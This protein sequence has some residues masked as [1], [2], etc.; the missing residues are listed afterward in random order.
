[1]KICLARSVTAATIFCG[2]IVQAGEVRVTADRVNLRAEPDLH[3]E[4]V[5]QV[6][7]GDLLTE[8]SRQGEWVEVSAPESAAVWVYGELLRDGAVSVSRLNVRGGPG[9]NYKPLGQLERG[10]KVVIRETLG[11]WVQI[12]PTP[13]VRLWIS[14]QY[15]EA[16]EPDSRKMPAKQ[17]PVPVEKETPQKTAPPAV[18][19]AEE[20]VAAAEEVSGVDSP[21]ETIDE[22][23]AVPV[24]PAGKPS[25]QPALKTDSSTSPP[26][27]PMITSEEQGRLVQLSGYLLR[28][29]PQWMV[30]VAPRFRL[31]GRDELNRS[32][33]LCH[34]E[35][36]LDRLEKYAGR[37]VTV[38]GHR[39]WFQ[40]D[41]APTVILEQIVPAP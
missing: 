24:E 39:Y 14:S 32:T 19:P 34:L 12:V 2:V 9:I 22:E 29:T 8:F 25:G 18:V 41:R 35:G 5:A 31:L 15:V 17:D 4:V 16:V 20:T 21:V 27:R 7:E 36:R 3:V 38:S 28:V 1:M 40:G 37:N 26:T 6:N 30:W 10:T 11:E 13:Q 23:P 33:T